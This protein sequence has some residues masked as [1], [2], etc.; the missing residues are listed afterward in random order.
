[1][2]AQERN[3][4]LNVVSVGKNSGKESDDVLGKTIP[5]MKRQIF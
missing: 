2:F 3:I 5:R 1:M 4:P